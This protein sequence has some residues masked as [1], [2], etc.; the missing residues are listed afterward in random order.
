MSSEK[1]SELMTIKEIRE[2]LEDTIREAYRDGLTEYGSTFNVVLFEDGDIG[3]DELSTPNE[4]HTFEK[5]NVC[6]ASFKSDENSTVNPEE[7]FFA[8]N[9]K[10]MAQE[11]I[12]RFNDDI[13]SEDYGLKIEINED[14]DSEGYSGEWECNVIKMFK[15]EPILQPTFDEL[16]EECIENAVDELD[17]NVYIE[18]TLEKLEKK[19]EE[20]LRNSYE[21]EK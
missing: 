13:L 10:D 17:V 20:N 19:E 11:L 3:I 18:S 16:I 12:K 15:E 21:E 9:Y 5:E 8:D 7:V 1:F 6:V 4:Y 2:E 14:E